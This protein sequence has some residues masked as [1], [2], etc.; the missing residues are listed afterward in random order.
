MKPRALLFL[1]TLVGLAVPAATAAQTTV[2]D[3]TAATITCTTL[4]GS[5]V[6]KPLLTLTPQQ[7]SLTIKGKLS[8]CTVSGAL[9]ADPPLQVV[10]GRLTAKL[11]VIGPASCITLVGGFQVTQPFVIKWKAAKGQ[12]L[13]LRSSTF[14]PDENGLVAG[15][16][17]L[18]LST[19][20]VFTTAGALAPESAFAGTSA[21]LVLVSAE[22]I[23]NMLGQCCT[24]PDFCP[25]PL[26]TGIEKLHFG[27]GQVRM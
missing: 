25:L 26:G 20:G 9:P 10:S 13:D 14:A 15:L 4:V 5:I 6:P 2:Y 27:I 16:V 3:T 12:A 24:D 23:M 21:A 18:G 17:D 8:G 22:D 7:T 19:Y 1:F 11:P